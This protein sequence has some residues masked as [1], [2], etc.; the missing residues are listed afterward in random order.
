MNLDNSLIEHYRHVAVVDDDAD[1]TK[2]I[3]DPKNPNIKKAFV[4]EITPED[5]KRY[6]VLTIGKKLVIYVD[7]RNRTV[8]S[9]IE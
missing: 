8:S 4:F 5:N 1:E 3:K 6:P 2:P 9:E 7:A